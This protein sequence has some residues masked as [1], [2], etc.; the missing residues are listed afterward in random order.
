MGG[1]NVKKQQKKRTNQIFHREV[2]RAKN[3]LSRVAR[4]WVEKQSFRGKKEAKRNATKKKDVKGPAPFRI[5]EGKGVRC[6][7][8][9]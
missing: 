5:E 4:F 3:H 8:I 6:K 1:K 2:R 7:G 9:F